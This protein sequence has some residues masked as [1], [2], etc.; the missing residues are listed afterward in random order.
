MAIST[1]SWTQEWSLAATPSGEFGCI[2]FQPCPGFSGWPRGSPATWWEGSSSTRACRS[3]IPPLSLLADIQRR[4]TTLSPGLPPLPAPLP[5]LTR[6]HLHR[7]Q[8]M[9]RREV[10]R[11]Q[12]VDGLPSPA[13]SVP[14][15]GS[16]QPPRHGI[17]RLGRHLGKRERERERELPQQSKQ[18][19][20]TCLS[21]FSCHPHWLP[22]ID[23]DLSCIWVPNANSKPDWVRDWK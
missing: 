1:P 16:Q 9:P 17:Q 2:A 21:K 5:R 6:L 19:R 22:Q 14:G 18:I 11:A 8:P 3:R 12:R 15:L 20:K 23:R 10:S 7:L 13:T 4:S